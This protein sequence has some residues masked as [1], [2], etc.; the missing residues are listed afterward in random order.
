MDDLA[1]LL[2]ALLDNL[3]GQLAPVVF[4]IKTLEETAL[5]I[6]EA[7]QNIIDTL[8]AAIRKKARE[9]REAAQ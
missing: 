2:Q 5:A 7:A 8:Q 4:P 1:S 9:M 3:P 6:E